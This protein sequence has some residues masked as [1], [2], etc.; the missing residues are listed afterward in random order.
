MSQ[1][2]SRIN[3]QE[4]SKFDDITHFGKMKELTGG[5]SHNID[6]PLLVSL[7]DVLSCT[8]LHNQHYR[9]L[10]DEPDIPPFIF[11]VVELRNEK[12]IES[13]EVVSSLDC[14]D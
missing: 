3:F 10:L 7:N 5:D 2:V 4:E 14:V 9:P 13:E 11:R 1:P 8:I 6:P 12:V